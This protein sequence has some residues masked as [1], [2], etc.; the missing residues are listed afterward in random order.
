MSVALGIAVAAGHNSR[1]SLGLAFF[2]GYMQSRL[3]KRR[4]R[5]LVFKVW[6]VDYGMSLPLTSVIFA[7]INIVNYWSP[8]TSRWEI[9]WWM[10]IHILAYFAFRYLAE[11]IRETLDI[12]TSASLHEG[13]MSAYTFLSIYTSKL[14][15]NISLFIN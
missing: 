2:R 5:R 12:Y 1:S 4:W 10:S 7:L 9:A 3:N 6:K 15:L 8:I 14:I 13:V 11:A